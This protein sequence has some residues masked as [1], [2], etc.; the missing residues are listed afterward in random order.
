M[1]KNSRWKTANLLIYEW[2]EADFRNLG[3][4]FSELIADYIDPSELAQMKRRDDEAH[5]LIGS[6][7][8]ND[9]IAYFAKRNYLLHFHGCGWRGEA[10]ESDLL[11][12]CFFNGV[13][14]PNTKAALEQARFRDSVEVVGDPA[15]GLLEKLQIPK[16]N[17]GDS[18]LIPHVVDRS[19]WM[20]D[21]ATIGADRIEEAKVQTRDNTV[22]KIEQL[23]GASFVLGGAMHACIVADYYGVPFAPFGGEW[24]DCPPKWKDWMESRGYNS[25]DLKFCT[26]VEEGREWYD[27]VIAPRRYQN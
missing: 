15:Y 21:P 22:D 1:K 26:S 2:R 13:R 25:D 16:A 19:W 17:H 7:I 12:F 5:F 27:R 6:H 8:Y 3:D 14:G 23:S 24:I 9:T 20:Y 11:E 4:A 18:L 10:L